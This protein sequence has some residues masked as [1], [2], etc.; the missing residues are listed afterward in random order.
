LTTKNVDVFVAHIQMDIL[1][2]YFVIFH[3]FWLLQK[4]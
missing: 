4:Y 1:E 3:R 2:A